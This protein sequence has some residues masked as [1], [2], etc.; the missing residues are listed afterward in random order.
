MEHQN[1]PPPLS[2]QSAPAA[3][4]QTAAAAGAVLP[5][6][7]PARPQSSR[8][9][10]V[11]GFVIA[12]VYWII[13][14]AVVFLGGIAGL[15][16]WLVVRSKKRAK[17][18]AALLPGYKGKPP[19]TTRHGGNTKPPQ[20]ES[21]NMPVAQVMQ[22]L[23]GNAPREPPVLMSTS[24]RIPSIPVLDAPVVPAAESNLFG[25][26]MT[27][28]SNGFHTFTPLAR[29]MMDAP[30]STSRGDSSSGTTSAT[31]AAAAAAA[32]IANPRRSSRN[33]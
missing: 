33:R 20:S 9:S 17:A 16:T 26:N 22:E 7:D 32:G 4:P 3:P 23:Y 29:K 27:R 15:V 14:S 10:R 21:L 31:A 2:Q 28:V 5:P 1:N 24:T 13:G 30:V 19:T 18:A 6:P 25:N 11:L 12:H 8:W